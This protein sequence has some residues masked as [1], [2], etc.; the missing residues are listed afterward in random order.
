MEKKRKIN[1]WA[2]RKAQLTMFV[3]IGLLILSTF[4]FFYYLQNYISQKTMEKR[5]DKVYSDIVQNTPISFYVSKCVEQSLDEGVYQIG[6][7]GGII[8]SNITGSI[9][10]KLK[11]NLGMDD[12][13]SVY[14]NGTNVT[15]VILNLNAK[16]IPSTEYD[17]NLPNYPCMP[18]LLQYGICKAEENSTPTNSCY[19]IGN[20]NTSKEGCISHVVANINTNKEDDTSA[21]A[22]G[23]KRFFYLDN[24]DNPILRPSMQEQ[25]EFFISNRTDSCVNLTG[26]ALLTGQNITKMPP[27]SNIT[28]GDNMILAYVK[29]PIVISVQGN[30]PIT[31][32]IYFKAQKNVRLGAI[33]R[34]VD[35]TTRKDNGILDYDLWD[36]LV[37]ET[38]SNY[39]LNKTSGLDYDV[40]VIKDKLY[41]ALL[42]EDYIFQFARQRRWPTLDYITQDIN[43]YKAGY[44]LGKSAYYYPNKSMGYD[45]FIPAGSYI[46]IEPNA[47]DPDERELIYNYSGWKQD[48][49]EYWN[50]TLENDLKNTLGNCT[51]NPANCMYKVYPEIG[52]LPPREWTNSNSYYFKGGFTG[53]VKI[54]TT[55]NESGPHIVRV[56]VSNGKYSDYQD[57][58]ILVFDTTQLKAEGYN[59]FQDIDKSVA[60]IEDPYYFETGGSTLF[61]KDMVYDYQDESEVTN[62]TSL[63]TNIITGHTLYS[64]PATK[65]ALL[66]MY[67]KIS[68]NDFDINNVTGPFDNNTNGT[69]N[70]R[71]HN[72][73]VS[74]EFTGTCP[75]G[76]YKKFIDVNVTQCVPHRSNIATYPFNK[77][78]ESDYNLIF[79]KLSINGNY[80]NYWDSSTDPFE[81]N[82]SCC[83]VSLVNGIYNITKGNECYHF[84]SYSNFMPNKSKEY[85]PATL[86]INDTEGFTNDNLDLNVMPTIEK[87]NG[88]ELDW[89]EMDHYETPF[90]QIPWYLNDVYHRIV[91]QQCSGTR[92]N[93]CSG[94]ITD[95]WTN[96]TPCNDKN[97]SNGETE[98][99]AGPKPTSESECWFGFKSDG[100][101]CGQSAESIACY[102]YTY[103]NRESFEK[104]YLKLSWATGICN[105][106]WRLSNGPDGGRYDVP[107]GQFLCQGACGNEGCGI[108]VN[109][110]DINSYDRKMPIVDWPG[111]I[112]E[113][114]NI[115]G[116][117]KYDLTMIG[118]R[119]NSNETKV[120]PPNISTARTWCD[121]TCFSNSG[122]SASPTQVFGVVGINY[123]TTRDYVPYRLV[124]AN[125]GIMNDSIGFLSVN[126][127]TSESNCTACSGPN[128]NAD[129][130]TKWILGGGEFGEYSGVNAPGCCGDDNDEYSLNCSNQNSHSTANCQNTPTTTTNRCC[131]AST[132]CVNI[133]G[134]CANTNVCQ[135]L[136]SYPSYCESGTWKDPD[137]ISN[138]CTT[139]GLEYS[140]SASKCCGDDLVEDNW[141][142]TDQNFGCCCS[143]NVIAKMNDSF[144]G[145]PSV[146]QW[147]LNGNYCS[148]EVWSSVSGAFNTNHNLKCG[149]NADSVKLSNYQ[150]GAK[151]DN[152]GSNNLNGDGICAV[153]SSTNS[154]TCDTSYACI[155]SSGIIKN[156]CNSCGSAN[157]CDSNVKIGLTP[158]YQN[159]GT[160]TQTSC[161][162]QWASGLSNTSLNSCDT[163][164]VICSA[165]KNGYVCDNVN[166]KGFDGNASDLRCDGSNKQCT[167]CN[168]TRHTKK[169][170]SISYLTQPLSND[171]CESGCGADPK[172]DGYKNNSCLL[173][174]SGYVGAVCEFNSEPDQTQTVCECMKP[175]PYGSNWENGKQCCD[176]T[177]DNWIFADTNNKNAC[178]DGNMTI[179][180]STNTCK[181][182][183]VGTD[184]Y[185]CDGKAGVWNIGDGQGLACNKESGTNGICSK[186]NLNEKVCCTENIVNKSNKYI[187][188]CDGYD[189]EMC[190]QSPDGLWLVFTQDGLCAENLC[191]KESPIARDTTNS[192]Y[193][194]KCDSHSTLQC[195][196]TILGLFNP[197]G[198]CQDY[199]S[200]NNCCLW[201]ENDQTILV[202]QKNSK[203]KCDTG[204][205][206]CIGNV[207]EK[208]SPVKNGIFKNNYRCSSN[209][210]CEKC[211]NKLNEAGKCEQ[212]CG[213]ELACNGI[214]APG[215][216]IFG[217]TIPATFCEDNECKRCNNAFVLKN[218]DWNAIDPI[219]FMIINANKFSCGCSESDDG[220]ACD[221]NMDGYLNLGNYID[222][223]CSAKTCVPLQVLS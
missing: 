167:M 183:T 145:N 131:D 195:E 149:C 62:H 151:C 29:F 34:I 166:A 46:E 68:P 98:T 190:E 54:N 120:P 174:R 171:I 63:V 158:G 150:N 6:I 95:T 82:H 81:G 221:G 72:I 220:Y 172:A 19:F 137:T 2:T 83:E 20:M 124:N 100:T 1:R 7:H 176:K 61:C 11:M 108:A 136:G 138:F 90:N 84:E 71:I 173:D 101:S 57:V 16:S 69:N 218:N 118:T 159:D 186:T 115:Y 125:A 152:T 215:M 23:K 43:L 139:C 192:K 60:S 126:L 121:G 202:E 199:S 209:N 180:N 17:T 13:E 47:T 112:L 92:G 189:G 25:L 107:S 196:D 113:N 96:S 40:F 156:D 155:N 114:N 154:Y 26:I 140:N 160:C 222:G 56:N 207:E 106:N 97:T 77:Y 70:Y 163:E 165:S 58:R 8:P 194:Q 76:Q 153:V 67:A 214:A 122:T 41:S 133:N 22:F 94:P 210:I 30:P 33:K 38:S 104:S 45:Y 144:C 3:I 201:N 65:I 55:A 35:Y 39:E 216:N 128:S 178:V 204:D 102:P 132:S 42:G 181:T 111:N 182:V 28:I 219:T 161:C 36:G 21:A 31:K 73:N 89:Y 116:W 135:K 9:L 129:Q 93:A 119:L 14:Y 198:L 52:N 78:N 211:N 127:D 169:Q 146:N 99:C 44:R 123:C 91:S 187:C 185:Y 4:T 188:G 79:G 170:N 75:G 64:G 49:N 85:F 212:G 142:S 24:G 66:N 27:S 59:Q 88:N 148:R 86:A 117:S 110:I 18:Y 177:G 48:Y 109:C 197:Q 51:D 184:T 87:V 130:K 143:G 15:M 10:P 141:N 191:D 37:N 74:I 162:T 5:V 205:N 223:Y 213:S 200:P 53:K 208:C 134:S 206:G 103:S 175:T 217:E 80:V 179:C 147:C 203:W 32:M 157:R 105:K 193:Y 164:K 168:F 50:S 12:P